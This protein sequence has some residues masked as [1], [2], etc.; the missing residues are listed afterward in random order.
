MNDETTDVRR[1][2]SD[3]VPPKKA[4]KSLVKKEVIPKAFIDHI[5]KLGFRDSDAQVLYENKDDWI[6]MSTGGLSE[7]SSKIEATFIIEFHAQPFQR[8]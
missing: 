3:V 8:K 1:K 2:V 7:A 6:G 5:R 4:R